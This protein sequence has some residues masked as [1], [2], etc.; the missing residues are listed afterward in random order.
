MLVKGDGLY[1]CSAFIWL[2]LWLGT[3][4]VCV[5]YVGVCVWLMLFMKATVELPLRWSKGSS[6]HLLPL[7]LALFLILS[8][9]PPIPH[10]LFFLC[11]SS[12]LTITHALFCSLLPSPFL[13][14]SS[15]ISLSLCFSLSLSASLSMSHTYY[16]II[17]VSFGI[18]FPL[19]FL[20]SISP[21]VFLSLPVSP[22]LSMSLS[23]LV[24]W[25]R[26]PPS[27]ECPGPGPVQ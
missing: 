14:H 17:L 12:S 18:I 22:P 26:F 25:P 9:S 2:Q 3:E 7:F 6:L 16:C 4:G 19:S 24:L 27:W 11:M 10:T 21:P 23:S 15:S 20:I 1:L 8:S 13:S 5:A